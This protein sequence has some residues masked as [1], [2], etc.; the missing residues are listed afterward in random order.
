VPKL[1]RNAG[2]IGLALTAYDVWKRLSPRQR[3]L[4]AKQAKKYGPQIASRAL[5]SARA[6]KASLRK[7]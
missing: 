1:P 3:R 7:R 4:I 6:A 2:P 5:E